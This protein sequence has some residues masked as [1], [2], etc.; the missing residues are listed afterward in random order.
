MNI[1]K[2]EHQY[3]LLHKFYAART[4]LTF[5]E[6]NIR[7]AYL[8][9]LYFELPRIDGA[10]DT[11]GEDS[12]KELLKAVFNIEPVYAEQ[13]CSQTLDFYDNWNEY[14]GGRLNECMPEIIQVARP[15]T[16]KKLLGNMIIECRDAISRYREG[17][18]WLEN[19]EKWLSDV[20]SNIHRLQ[21]LLDGDAVKPEWG[22]TMIGRTLCSGRVYVRNDNKPDFP[23]VDVY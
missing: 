3:S 2:L 18:F 4:S 22:W 13:R 1:Y 9:L 12:G 21:Q 15:D 17:K 5:H 16:Y 20:G 23:S 10:E 8:Q 19:P 7:C 6:L 11:I 14:C